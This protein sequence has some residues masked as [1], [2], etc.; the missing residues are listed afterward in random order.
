M[1]ILLLLVSFNKFG[2]ISDSRN[3][4]ISGCQKFRKFEQ[5]LSISHGAYWWMTPSIFFLIITSFE[6]F[7]PVVIIILIFGDSFFNSSINGIDD[8]ASPTLAAWIQ[9]RLPF[10]LTFEEKPLL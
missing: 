8:K 10:G 9:T 6:V 2:Q 3:I 4:A 5:K 1:G 7:V